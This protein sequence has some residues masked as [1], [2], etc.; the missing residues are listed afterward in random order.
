MIITKGF[1]PYLQGSIVERLSIGIFVLR[2]IQQCQMI[3]IHC[4][5]RMVFPKDIF[6]Y[7]QST[8][9]E[10]LSFDIFALGIIQ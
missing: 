10:R 3:Q 5:L 8:L 4:N 9:I 2:I 1:F 6:I 7:C